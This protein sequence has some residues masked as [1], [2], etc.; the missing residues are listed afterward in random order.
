MYGI[1]VSMMMY[2][3]KFVLKVL[4]YDALISSESVAAT[5]VF[6]LSIRFSCTVMKMDLVFIY[7]M[8]LNNFLLILDDSYSLDFIVFFLF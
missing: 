5:R 1:M 8:I 4:T 6:H 3:V 2:L 7:T